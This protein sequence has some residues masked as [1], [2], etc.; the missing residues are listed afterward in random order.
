MSA[1][2]APLLDD[3]R[4]KSRRLMGRSGCLA[5]TQLEE[6]THCKSVRRTP[7]DPRKAKGVAGCTPATPLLSQRLD[8]GALARCVHVVGRVAR[9]LPTQALLH[10][11]EGTIRGQDR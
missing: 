2:A 6:I 1:T 3:P 10:L 7:A 9:V 8:E 4:R 11:A 5:G